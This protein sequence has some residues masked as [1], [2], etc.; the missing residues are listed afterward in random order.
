MLS[1]KRRTK[2]ISVHFM[3][4][5]AFYRCN[6]S[7]SSPYIVSSVHQIRQHTPSFKSRPTRGNASMKPS[8]PISSK[9]SPPVWWLA[10][11]VTTT[12]PSGPS[13]PNSAKTS[14]VISFNRSREVQN[15]N[16]RRMPSAT[17]SSYSPKESR[18]AG[19]RTLNASLP[20][21]ARR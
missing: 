3:V 6:E 17:R 5:F 14:F 21:A 20:K 7:G 15:H 1:D 9:S 18:A 13:A 4:F 8:V 10:D 2:S 11:S 16:Q 19:S 12:L